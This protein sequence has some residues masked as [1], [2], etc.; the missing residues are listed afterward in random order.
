LKPANFPVGS[1]E[2]RAAARS[3]LR[4]KQSKLVRL[5][6]LHSVPRPWYGKGPAP[7]DV[8][9]AYSW[10]EGKDGRMMRLVYI[11]HVWVTRDK[12]CPVCP[13]CGKPYQKAADCPN[14]HLVSYGA[15][16]ADTHIPDFS[17]PK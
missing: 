12:P 4:Q 11:P 2:S 9:R 16:C 17:R 1:P 14:F 7:P 8:P 5:Q 15:D 3:L 6:F 13:G 10:W